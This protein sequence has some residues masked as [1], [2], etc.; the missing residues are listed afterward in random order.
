M[1]CNRGGDGILLPLHI[2]LKNQDSCPDEP[3]AD[4]T[5]PENL[6]WFCLKRKQLKVKKF[7][8]HS[9]LQRI[10]V[11]GHEL[12]MIQG[13]LLKFPS[14]WSTEVSALT[15]ITLDPNTFSLVKYIWTHMRINKLV[16]LFNR[17]P[18][19]IIELKFTL[20]YFTY[21]MNEADWSLLYWFCNQLLSAHNHSKGQFVAHY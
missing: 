17:T 4:N 20:S 5:E 2:R 6:C 14:S 3:K 1:G 13:T 16:N 15:Q 8:T 7:P 9:P 12:L 21:P 11:S 18:D 10:Y 19:T